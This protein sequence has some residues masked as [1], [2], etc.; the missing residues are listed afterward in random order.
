MALHTDATTA[1]IEVLPG[2]Y[3]TASGDQLRS[4][5]TGDGS[6]VRFFFGYAGWGAG[7]LEMELQ[8]GAWRTEPTGLR[9]VFA[10]QAELW[11]RSISEAAGWEV[12]ETLR[13]KDVPLIRP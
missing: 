2:L 7:Q 9:H 5:V 4:L 13:I 11:E 1:E 6:N 10:I 12:L 8:A 3:F